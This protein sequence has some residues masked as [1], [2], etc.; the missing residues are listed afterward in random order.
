MGF[1]ISAPIREF[2]KQN[3]DY[4]KSIETQIIINHFMHHLT[5]CSIKEVE[6]LLPSAT[7]TSIET[8]YG[9]THSEKL[10]K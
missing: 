9:Y 10:I 7:I 1:H 2:I 5:K 3:L 4:L 6:S 8:Q